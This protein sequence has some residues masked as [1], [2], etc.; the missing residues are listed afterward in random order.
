MKVSAINNQQL[1]RGCQICQR[2]KW[3]CIFLTYLCDA[4]CSFCPAPFKQLDKTAS[5]FGCDL[6]TLSKHLDNSLFEGISFSGGECF[7][8]FD[9][10]VEWLP[11]LKRR[12]P[13]FYYWAYTNAIALDEDQMVI[14]ASK[15][16]NEIRFNI[17]A[18][19]YGSTV[20]LDKIKTAATI[21]DFVAVEIPSIPEDYPK[22]EP[23][24]HVLDDMN[25]NYL[26]LH[27]YIVVNGDPGTLA[28]SGTFLMNKEAEIR[29]D[30][31]SMPNSER[32][33]SYC[34]NNGLRFIINNC[35][36]DQKEMQMLQRRLVMGQM[37]KQH[38]DKIMNDGILET[39]FVYP[40]K[41]TYSEAQHLLSL[42]GVGSNYFVHPDDVDRNF[43]EH[44]SG[45]IAKVHFIPP[46]SVHED[47]K[48]YQIELINS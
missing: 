43:I 21:F 32:I 31:N 27:E 29:Y 13:H 5:A 3:L 15:G 30:L 28:G 46:M 12:F 42:N 36:L 39:L 47:R 4:K 6:S 11:Y 24:L 45:T 1:S 16:L 33:M 10:M 2:G 23:V 14:L 48:L 44:H 20:I 40:Q 8:V 26:N 38:Y 37:L 7:L 35:S 34:R 18:T 19:N 17:A 9:R 41:V 22:L 25:V